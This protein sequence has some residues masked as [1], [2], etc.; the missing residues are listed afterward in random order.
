MSFTQPKSPDP[1]ATA[2]MQQ[3]YNYNAAKQQQAINSV[4][5]STPY[6]SLTYDKDP[7]SPAGYSA[8]VT[9]SPA[10]QELLNQFQQTQGTL[11]GAAGNLSK[12]FDGLFSQ[13]PNLDPSA[14]TNQ[15]MKWQQDY[16]NPIFKQQQSNTDAQ[17]RNQGLTPGSEAYNNAQNLLARNQGDVTNQFFAQ[18]EPLAFNQ[19]V[20][21]YQLPRQTLQSALGFALSGT[22]PT[23]P[24]F[25]QTP[26]ET[27]NPANYA[28]I[29]Q[30]NFQ[31]QQ[32]QFE[33]TMSG[34][35]QIA[36]GIGNFAGGW[37][38]GSTGG[39][40]GGIPGMFGYAAAG[41]NPFLGN[42]ARNPYYG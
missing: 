26:Q 21:E 35:G 28:G 10:Q 9:L 41:S 13:A 16:I 29:A 24:S 23:G 40:G 5:Q 30:Q 15:L 2:Q 33:N 27:I 12:Q 6:G 38:G 37:G 11:G 42:G 4:N 31:N 18:S 19:A 3:G 1:S 25:Q 14:T 39:G 32:K 8:N 36:G 34:L 22:Q 20:T 7:N 17:L